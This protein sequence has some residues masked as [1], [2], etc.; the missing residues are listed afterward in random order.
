MRYRDSDRD[1]VTE[2]DVLSVTGGV[3]A[4][5]YSYAIPPG[6]TVACPVTVI[7]LATSDALEELVG[8]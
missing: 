3:T 7:S 4:G 5:V 1:S 8:A 6:V 2:R